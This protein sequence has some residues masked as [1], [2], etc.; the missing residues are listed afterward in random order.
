MTIYRQGDV[1]LRKIQR[2]PRRKLKALPRINSKIVLAHGETRG[3]AHIIVDEGDSVLSQDASNRLWLEIFGPATLRH[4][5][6]ETLQDGDHDEIALEKG[7][8]EV[9]RQKEYSPNANLGVRNV[10]D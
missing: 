7:V 10:E 5:D 1:L 3:H 6:L 4:G 8:Y 9:V 2:R